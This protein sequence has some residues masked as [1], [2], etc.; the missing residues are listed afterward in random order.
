MA[1]IVVAA[2]V[3]VAVVDDDNTEEGPIIT[4]PGV[5]PASDVIATPI[6]VL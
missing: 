2:V 5:R 4:R 6:D 3:A 1:I